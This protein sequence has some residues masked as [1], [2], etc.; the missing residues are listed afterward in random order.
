MNLVMMTKSRLLLA[1]FLLLSAIVI[2]AICLFGKQ[3]YTIYQFTHAPLPQTVVTKLAHNQET[4]VDISAAH[5]FGNAPPVLKQMPISRSQL[6]LTG[7]VKSLTGNSKAYIAI[8]GQPSKI[9]KIGELLTEQMKI[10][11]ITA[12][13]V[14]LQNAGQLEKL[15]LAREALI[16]KTRAEEQL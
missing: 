10:Y 1:S 8:A 13:T 6:Q 9:Y 14:I 12:D 11:D 2:I 4:F 5:L 7:I 16:F 3:L 15:L